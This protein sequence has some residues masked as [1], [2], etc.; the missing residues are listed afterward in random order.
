MSFQILCTFYFNKTQRV[1][2]VARLHWEDSSVGKGLAP[3]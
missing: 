2:A 3:H 1:N